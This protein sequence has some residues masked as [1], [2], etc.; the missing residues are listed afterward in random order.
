MS[1]LDRTIITILGGGSVWTPYLIQL[2]DQEEWCI[3]CEFR[4]YGQNFKTLRDTKDFI[5]CSATHIKHFKIMTEFKDAV[6]NSSIIV[7]QVRIGGQGARYKDETVSMKYNC[8]ADESLGL[9]GLRSVKRSLPF[10]NS[11]AKAIQ[12]SA[13]DAWILNLTNPTD[14]ISRIWIENGCRKVLSLCEHAQLHLKRLCRYLNNSISCNEFGFIGMIHMGWAIPPEETELKSILCE[15]PELNA[16]INRFGAIPTK[17]RRVYDYPEILADEQKRA[18]E[19]RA[20]VLLN[21]TDLL[22]ETIRNRDKR[23]YNELI[24]RRNP[25]WYSEIVIPA[26]KALM[27]VQPNKMIIGLPSGHRIAGL[28]PNVQVETW[29][30]LDENGPNPLSPPDNMACIQDVVELGDTRDLLIRYLKDQRDN[31]LD[32]YLRSDAFFRPL[33]RNKDYKKLIFS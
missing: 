31:N 5:L 20:K 29:T 1:N 6:S 21:L 23:K 4:L 9:G 11:A 25:V 8:V 14:L 32:N 10:I 22:R 28:N 26:I 3:N 33:L 27:G 7:N 15:D 16:Y 18:K 19:S 30:N 24:R 17:W 13:P 12:K 2:L